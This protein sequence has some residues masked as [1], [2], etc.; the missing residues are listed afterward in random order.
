MAGVK[1]CRIC[2][3][4]KGLTRNHIWLDN[5]TIVE[6]KKPSHRMIFIENENILEVF[7]LIEEI[8][9]LSLEKIVI[10]SQRKATYDYVNSILPDM[11]KKVMRV[12]SYRPV[13]RNLTMLGRTLGLGDVSLLDMRIKGKDGDFVKLGIRNA[14]FLPSFCG[15]VTGAMEVVS[16]RDCSVSYQETSPGYFEVTTFVSTH[17]KELVER[18]PWRAYANKPGGA[19]LEKCPGC[20]G[21]KALSSYEFD[22]DA[23]VILKKASG[24]RMIIDGPAEFEAILDELER[25][26]GED[27]PRVLVEAQRRFVKGGF[28]DAGEVQ[29]IG[30]FRDHLALRGLGNLK[31][32]SFD[33]GRLRMHLENPCLHLLLV[34]LAQGLFELV[35]DC[36]GTVEWELAGDGDL[37]VEV[38]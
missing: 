8:V 27:I 22:L 24:R 18:L 14:F 20:G 35:F 15:M 30:S 31:E 5:G 13:V 1:V 12:T 26:L 33:D 6:R 4:T 9:G 29:E 17:P 37:F 28:Y 38:S 2:G 25:E 10:E 11:V 16:G 32:V 36:E 7:K 21:P 19:A 23:G 34:G 3:A